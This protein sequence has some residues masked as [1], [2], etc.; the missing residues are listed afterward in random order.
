MSKQA[1]QSAKDHRHPES[2]IRIERS[3]DLRYRRQQSELTIPLPPGDLEEKHVQSLCDDFHKEYELTFGF[4]LS[5]SP[6]EIVNLR[7][8]TT[9]KISKPAT[10]GFT[11]IRNVTPK[12]GAAKRE[13]FFGAE[14]GLIATPVLAAE[15]V[16]ASTMR[17]PLLIDTYDS[18]IVVPPDSRIRRSPKGNLVITLL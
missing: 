1:L 18:T 3:A 6:V 9:I 10:S 14:H 13:A 12:K 16:S 5:H 17:G 2:A 8:S 11:G 7:V 4:R 15:E